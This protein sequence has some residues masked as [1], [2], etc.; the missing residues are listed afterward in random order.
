MLRRG[1]IDQA[2]ARRNILVPVFT[3]G[4]LL[5]ENAVSLFDK[6][7]NLVPI[8]SVEGGEDETDARRGAGTYAS[9]EKGMSALGEKGVLFGASVTVTRENLTFV[10]S[11]AFLGGLREHGCKIV[12]YVDY[13]PADPGTESLAPGDAERDLLNA[14]LLELRARPDAM[15]FVAFPGD[16]QFSGGCLAAG[17]GFFHINPQGSAEPC[18][19]SPV[20]DV[21]LKNVSLLEALESPLFTRLR[22]SELLA[23]HHDG[24]CAL[25]G[26]EDEVRAMK[27]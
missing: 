10:T 9:L 24:A 27:E 1:V 7:R 5:E 12:F 18:P 23:G 11:D 13:V 19:F 17:R 22:A 16:E 8:V 26:H 21:N 2:A 4:T 15:V 25:F 20:S 3:Y 14:R 6:H